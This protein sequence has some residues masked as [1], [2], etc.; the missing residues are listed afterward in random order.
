MKSLGSFNL[1]GNMLKNIRLEEV[2]DFPLQPEVGSFIFKDRKL[3]V[4]VDFNSGTPLWVPLTQ[5]IDTYIHTQNEASATWIIE[6]N[7]GTS[8]AIV[9][10]FDQDNRVIIPDD[11]DM[12]LENTAVVTFNIPMAG[13]AIIVLGSA[14]G[15]PKSN[16]AFSAAFAESTEWTVNHGLG[17]NP[18]IRVFVGSYEIQPQ[19]IQHVSTTQAIVYFS[20]PTSGRVTCA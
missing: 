18:V 5:E 9:Q 6:H 3:M 1:L 4:C 19:S 16:V 14:F 2:T 8:T 10:V 17:Y 20:T 15:T 11:I 7:L 12:S 13:R